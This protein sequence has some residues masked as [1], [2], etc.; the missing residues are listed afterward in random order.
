MS[1]D[2]YKILGIDR[3]AS[4]SDIKKAYRKMAMKYHPDKNNGDSDSE[5]KF[6]EAS[7]AY[8]ILSNDN[9]RSHYDRFGTT[10][11]S[12]SGSSDGFNMDD[13]FSQFNDIFG[14]GFGFNRQRNETKKGSDLRVKVSLTIQEIIH[15]CNKKIKYKRKNKCSNC[16]GQGGE[17]VRDCLTC[18][19]TGRRYIIQNTPFGQIRQEGECL[20]CQGSGKQIKDKCRVCFGTG[21]EV[22]EETV[23]IEI[24]AG[25]S[26]NMKFNMKGFGNYTRG[27]HSGDL[28]IYIE[29]IKENYFKRVGKDILIE[30]NISVID[31]IVGNN[32][33]VKTPHGELTVKINP[34]TQHLDKIKFNGKGIPDLNYGGIGDLYVIPHIV[35]PRNINLEEKSILDKLKN[36]ESFKKLV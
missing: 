10:D 9:K 34:G 24:P 6:K 28:I 19:G 11:N 5:I 20:D 25:V 15:G 1:K 7:E 2:Y 21:T 12:F 3:N 32:L 18:N 26:D 33:K 31:A 29:E 23:E 4:K 36:S 35:I 8:E 27:G 13:I 17:N 30:K 22:L 14:G 16:N